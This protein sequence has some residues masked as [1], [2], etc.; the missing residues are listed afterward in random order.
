MAAIQKL[1]TEEQWAKIAPLLP[2]KS[3]VPKGVAHL[4]PTAECSKASCGFCAPGR[5]GRTCPRSIPVPVPAGGGFRDWEEEG[6]WLKIWRAFLSTLDERG[7][8]GLE[9]S[10]FDGS[11]AP[12]KKGA[13]ASGQPSGAKARSGWWWS[14]ARVFLWEAPLT[15]ASSA[16]VKLLETT[17]ETITVPR[18]GRGRPRKNPRRLIVDRAYDS[19]P[20]RKRGGVGLN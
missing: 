7:S 4:P 14:T 8:P 15:S 16:E 17:V 2:R 18:K 9:R 3:L 11:F 1:L 10:V 13:L 5:A 12:A 20:L 19:D 6:V